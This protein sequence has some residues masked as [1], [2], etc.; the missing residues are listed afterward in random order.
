LATIVLDG[1][2]APAEP[3][4]IAIAVRLLVSGLAAG[5]V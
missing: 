5:V 4:D 2:L 1:R 3:A